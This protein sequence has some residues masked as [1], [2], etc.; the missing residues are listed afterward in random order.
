[1]GHC[2]GQGSWRQ[3]RLSEA[4]GASRQGSTPAGVDVDTAPALRLTSAWSAEAG[5][6]ALLQRAKAR[7]LLGA[8]G[9]DITNTARR[10]AA[11]A[12]SA[13]NISADAIL[14]VAAGGSQPRTRLEWH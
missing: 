9:S 5:D 11:W 6:C 8:G 1:M 4:F 13:C 2:Q 12:A 7:A 14:P 10:G 3:R